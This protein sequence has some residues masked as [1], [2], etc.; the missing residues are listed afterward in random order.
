V[1]PAA[2]TK[3]PAVA[4]AP[5]IVSTVDTAADIDPGFFGGSAAAV[6]ADSAIALAPASQP[7]RHAW[8][9]LIESLR[10][11]LDQR[12]V[13]RTGRDRAR[14]EEPISVVET[15]V[16]TKRRGSRPQ[17][18]NKPPRIPQRPQNEWGLFDPEQ[19]GFAALLAKLDEITH[20][21]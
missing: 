9:E 8:V 16:A 10:L 1:V 17:A 19:C 21:K 14:H 15:Q 12:R 3:E 18:S 2:T 6:S 5:P 4:A 13:E 7:P 20:A 11:D